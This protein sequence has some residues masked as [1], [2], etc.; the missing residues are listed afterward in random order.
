MIIPKIK[1]NIRSMITSLHKPGYVYVLSNPSLNGWFK[2]GHTYRPPYRR[3]DELSKTSLPTPFDVEYAKFFWN[4]PDA[5][6]NM[7]HFLEKNGNLR[8]KEFFLAN[9]DQ[10]IVALSELPEPPVAKSPS[11]EIPDLDLDWDDTLQGRE[12]LWEWAEKDLRSLDPTVQRNAWRQME[13]L[14]ARGWAEGSWRLADLLLRA[15][16]SNKGME[17]ASWVLDA[18]YKQGLNEAKFRAAWI[19][20]WQSLEKYHEF[21]KL[22]QDHLRKWGYDPNHWSSKNIETVL[23]ELNSWELHPHRQ[24]AGQWGAWRALLNSGTPQK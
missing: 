20:S 12:D 24:Q 7:H 14:S 23:V 18:A 19:R 17:R 13:Q 8:K 9:V 2:V 4:A 1:P 10:I 15:D 21:V 6:K 3:A 22:F 5:E 11:F 16:M